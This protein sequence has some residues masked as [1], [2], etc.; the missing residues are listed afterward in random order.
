M[1]DANTEDLFPLSKG[2]NRVQSRPS[3]ATL[4][5]WALRGIRGIQLETV[6][7]G[8]RRFT[9]SQAIARFMTRLSEPQAVVDPPASAQRAEEK[10]IAA[11]RAAAMF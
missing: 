9:S 2:T 5:R 11:K 4:W 6:M 10:A 1:I 8:G 3:A 7:I